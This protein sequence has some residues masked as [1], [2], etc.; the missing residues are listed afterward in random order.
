[1]VEPATYQEAATHPE[2][3]HAMAEEIAALSILAPRILF[4]YHFMSLLSLASG[5]TR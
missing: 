3:Q 1:L 5:C 4:L 2:W